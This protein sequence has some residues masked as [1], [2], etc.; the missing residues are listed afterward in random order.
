MSA[1]T[2]A[3]LALAA[4]QS[5][6]QAA[7]SRITDLGDRFGAAVKV[8]RNLN[9]YVSGGE[10]AFLRKYNSAG[11]MVWNRD[12]SYWSAATLGKYSELHFTPNGDLLHLDTAQDFFG[13]GAMMSARRVSPATGN[14]LWEWQGRLNDAYCKSQLFQ[15][16]G[17]V[18]ILA[19]S[20]E[21]NASLYC[22][23]TVTGQQLWRYDWIGSTAV[24]FYVRGD[25][26]FVSTNSG[27]QPEFTI[28]GPTGTE[29][30]RF[31]LNPG[32]TRVPVA[33]VESGDDMLFYSRSFNGS[34]Y[35]L[36]VSRMDAAFNPL[37]WFVIAG[38]GEAA[39]K[40]A[41]TAQGSDRRFVFLKDGMYDWSGYN[42][43]SCLAAHSSS[44]VPIFSRLTQ[45]ANGFDSAC[46]ATDTWGFAYLGGENTATVNGNVVR[47][48][49]LMSINPN[50]GASM[51]SLN[52]AERGVDRVRDLEVL[53][54]GDT[55]LVGGNKLIEVYQ[56][57]IAANDWF[58]CPEGASIAINETAGLR[59]N[60]RY[61]Q[62][63]ACSIVAQPTKG[64]VT[65]GAGGGFTYLAT[66]GQTGSD[67]FRYRLTRGAYSSEATVNIRLRHTIG[68]IIA[69]VAQL[70]SGELFPLVV[71]MSSPVTNPSGD[72]VSLRCNP[73]VV[74]MPAYTVMPNG[75][76]TKRIEGNQA[77]VVG[78]N[79]NIV[80]SATYSGRTVSTTR[81]VYA[82]RLWSFGFWTDRVYG[83]T[84][85][86]G[87]IRLTGL[88][89]NDTTVNLSSN[90]TVAQI[91]PSVVIPRNGS[92]A[93][94]TLYTAPTMT[95]TT[96]T[97]TASL[98]PTT[99]A[100]QVRILAP[101]LDIA[102]FPVDSLTGGLNTSLRLKIF[103]TAPSS[104][105]P[106]VLRASSSLLLMPPQ[107][108]VPSNA[109]LVDVA[110]GTK[111]TTTSTVVSVTCTAGSVTRVASITLTP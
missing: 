7:L 71:T 4:C 90:T 1:S 8:D 38:A 69:D 67:T 60:D 100:R 43:V 58:D 104:G 92:G 99:I 73:P 51:W 110:V 34:T 2:I 6:S 93:G 9:T 37:G 11:Q 41:D 21:N 54:N 95:E 28:L 86:T 64:T 97:L 18:A 25:Y 23:N 109:S 91:S 85:I 14:A 40:L 94:V 61:A 72:Y 98:G 17:L 80:I 22:L 87:E 103:G 63:A 102:K 5:Y 59:I 84:Q 101:A 24:D 20:G 78:T 105:F 3:F 27:D 16:G 50:S 111:A 19:H 96:A 74:S 49:L 13:S 55:V 106:V 107:G 57:P 47:R 77:P 82:A 62:M 89:A 10:T 48:G 46:A 56:R 45:G 36:T 30:R 29:E 39:W 70:D 68:Q 31:V 108:V 32:T 52:L 42:P 79:T 44:E 75:W 76:T 53:S 35:D 12:Y 65:L 26:L 66:A 15:N 88:A 33:L 81:T 83:G